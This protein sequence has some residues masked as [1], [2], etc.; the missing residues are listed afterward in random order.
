MADMARRLASLE[1]KH[2]HSQDIIT[3]FKVCDCP[4][5]E[6]QQLM[7]AGPA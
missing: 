5:A 3:A 1:E 4:T 7:T 6:P 2:S